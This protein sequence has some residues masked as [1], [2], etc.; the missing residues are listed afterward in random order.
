MPTSTLLEIWTEEFDGLYQEGK[1]LNLIIH[2]Q[3][4]GRVS[5]VNA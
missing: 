3:I 2:P 5:R 1:M 4:S